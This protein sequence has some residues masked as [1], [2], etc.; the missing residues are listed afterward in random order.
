MKKVI[1]FIALLLYLLT[2]NAEST[3]T[4]R[5]SFAKHQFSF[6]ENAFGTKIIPNSI[7]ATYSTDANKPG[8][9]LISVNIGLP[10]G[11]I[12]KNVRETVS[13]ELILNN[14]VIATNPRAIPTNFN[15]QLSSPKKPT[16]NEST[17]PNENVQ[18]IGT[19]EIG[20]YTMVR[21]DMTHTP[22]GLPSEADI[23]IFADWMKANRILK[24]DPA[25]GD[26]VF[27]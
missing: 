27:Q 13:E 7:M 20:N 25:Y 14:I 23:K 18:Y 11:V 22:T 26:V 4:I 21:F 3:K 15:G 24:K 19:S 1:S 10:K 16:Y 6:I 17:Y 5:L 12:F 9:P 8:L 2:A